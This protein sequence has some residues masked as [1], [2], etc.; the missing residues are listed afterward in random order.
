M[1]LF[2]SG[3]RFMT[4]EPIKSMQNPTRNSLKNVGSQTGLFFHL[5]ATQGEMD[6][7]MDI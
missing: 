1:V 7:Q 3:A 5:T 6:S 4:L 2:G